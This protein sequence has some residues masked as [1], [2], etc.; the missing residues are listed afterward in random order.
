MSISQLRRPSRGLKYSA[1]HQKAGKIMISLASEQGQVVMMTD[2]Q[3]DQ[4]RGWK[5]KTTLSI[6]IEQETR[7]EMNARSD[8]R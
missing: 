5:I 8:N 4:S 7:V 6:S 1:Y 2:S 3:L